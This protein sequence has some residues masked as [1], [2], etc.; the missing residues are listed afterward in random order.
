MG[1]ALARTH[2]MNPD[3][4]GKRVRRKIHWSRGVPLVLAP[5]TISNEASVSLAPPFFMVM[6]APLNLAVDSDQR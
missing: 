2:V 1:F 4:Q 3:V 6:S 5:I